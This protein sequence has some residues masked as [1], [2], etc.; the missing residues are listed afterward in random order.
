MMILH[1]SIIIIFN[2]FNFSYLDL[3]TNLIVQ[4][5]YFDLIE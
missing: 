2:I 3:N 5:N 4:S 1:I